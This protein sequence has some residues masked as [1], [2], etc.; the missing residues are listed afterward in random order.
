MSKKGG[1][2]IL[3]IFLLSTSATAQKSLDL[4][5]VY[6]PG[7][8]IFRTY[9]IYQPKGFN[10]NVVNKLMIGFHPYGPGTWNS[11]TWRDTLKS[12][13]DLVDVLLICPDGGPDGRVDDAVDYEFAK[14]LMDT[15]IAQYQI[16]PEKIFLIGF[17]VGGKAVYEFG[18]KHDKEIKGMIP[19]G[20]A[21]DGVD[22]SSVIHKA[23][24]NSFYLV[25]GN[26]DNPNDRYF[27]IKA[28]LEKHEALV[29]AI[30]MANIGHTINFPNRNTILKMAFDYV[31]TESCD[32]T[33]EEEKEKEEIKIFPTILS[34]GEKTQMV[35]GQSEEVK[36]LVAD[37]LG[38]LIYENKATKSEDG[39]IDID[40][41]EFPKGLS[42]IVVYRKAEKRVF[43]IMITD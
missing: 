24:C 10:P 39:I 38:R 27:P 12:F 2:F 37:E 6:P 25:H 34:R 41:S 22:F 35:L 16:D 36:I 43:R 5:M 30:L 3:F 23:K 29:D 32:V 31:D 8:G 17:S 18:L 40:T 19:I 21:I 7:T 28:D 9:S 20:A 26:K 33:G 13:V 1:L 4:S 14:V 11:I 15:M 42:F